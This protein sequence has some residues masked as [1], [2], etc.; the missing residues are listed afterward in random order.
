MLPRSIR[1]FWY[2]RAPRVKDK[3][4]VRKKCYMSR[5]SSS[6]HKVNQSNRN[7]INYLTYRISYVI[8]IMGYLTELGYNAWLPNMYGNVFW[9][10]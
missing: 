7:D 2:K 3:H 10:K 6:K 4:K 9:K 1:I 8:H 5:N